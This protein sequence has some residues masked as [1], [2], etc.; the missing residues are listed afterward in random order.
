[1]YKC[2]SSQICGELDRPRT[3]EE[4]E[5]AEEKESDMEAGEKRKIRGDLYAEIYFVF[6]ILQGSPDSK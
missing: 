2:F 6:N 1:M 4:E 3:G 5:V